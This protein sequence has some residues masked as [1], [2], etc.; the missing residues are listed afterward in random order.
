MARRKE[1]PKAKP[2]R[3]NIVKRI[4]LIRQNEQIISKLK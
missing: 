1:K 3:G 2:N 4:K